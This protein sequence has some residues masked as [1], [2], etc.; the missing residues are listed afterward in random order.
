MSPRHRPQ[1]GSSS[2]RVWLHRCPRIQRP[3]FQTGTIPIGLNQ[4]RT[5][6]HC[7]GMPRAI[8]PISQRPLY[9]GIS[10]PREKRDLPFVVRFKI[11]E[12][13][14]FHPSPRHTVDRIDFQGGFLPGRLTV[15]TKIVMSR[16]DENLTDVHF[17]NR[18]V[19]HIDLGTQDPDGSDV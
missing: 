10:F 9:F 18:H 1:P 8:V 7:G 3:G 19:G 13:I 6:P 4:R 15:V 14:P 2:N 12:A 17:H 16:G 5:I 11:V